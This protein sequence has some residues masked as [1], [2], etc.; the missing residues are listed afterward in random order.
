[1]TNPHLEVGDLDRCAICHEE[2]A[3][4]REAEEKRGR[5]FCADC[6]AAE[7]DRDEDYERAA[8]RARSND[9]ADTDGRDWT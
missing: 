4:T 3:D 8:S 9:F 2:I 5:L 7:D 6:L 1:M